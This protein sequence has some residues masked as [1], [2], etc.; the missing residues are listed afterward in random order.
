MKN[1]LIFIML[2]LTFSSFGQKIALLSENFKRPILYT[3][4]VS[5]EQVSNGYFA[6]NVKDFDT[7]IGSLNYLKNALI[8]LSRSKMKSWEFRAGNTTLEITSE[9]FAYGDKYNVVAISSFND[10]KTFFTITTEKNNK[11]NSGRIE[12]MINYIA[13]NRTFFKSAYEITPKFYEVI[14]IKE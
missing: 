3:D 11:R 10:V 5:V 12:E 2:L 8:G 14:I 9:P 7:L 13:K 4:S 6:V 1:N